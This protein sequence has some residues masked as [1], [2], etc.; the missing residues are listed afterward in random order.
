MY[1]PQISVFTTRKESMVVAFGEIEN[2]A[3][4]MLVPKISQEVPYSGRKSETY[5]ALTMWAPST[6]RRLHRKPQGGKYWMMLLLRSSSP[7]AR[8]ESTQ[9]LR[10]TSQSVEVIQ[11]LRECTKHAKRVYSN[12]THSNIQDGVQQNQTFACNKTLLYKLLC[13]FHS[14]FK[15]YIHQ[16][17][18]P[19]STASWEQSSAK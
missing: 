18:S 12:I 19:I 5:R 1:P 2:N 13:T 4:C 7:F 9:M 15:A 14:C 16:A 11:M 10:D 17:L 8:Y 3:K 6:P